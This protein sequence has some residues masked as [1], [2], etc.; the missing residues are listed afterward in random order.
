MREADYQISGKVPQGEAA[1]GCE[2]YRYG[3]E[4]GIENAYAARR[5]PTRLSRSSGL[6][7]ILKTLLLS[8]GTA[9]F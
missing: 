7:V 1:C 9:Y 2:F 8:R 6:A 4:R 3:R 5:T